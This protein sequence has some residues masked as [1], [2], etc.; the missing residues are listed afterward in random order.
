MAFPKTYY[1]RMAE[2]PR[3]IVETDIYLVCDNNGKDYLA[4]FDLRTET[5]DA[6]IRN[7]RFDPP[8]GYK[9]FVSDLSLYIKETDRPAVNDL[10]ENL[11]KNIQQQ[12]PEQFTVTWEGA[13][14]TV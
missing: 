1:G 6:L 4:V 10:I 5:F 9:K 3:T 8:E 2:D 12:G 11:L 7:I 13:E 14:Q